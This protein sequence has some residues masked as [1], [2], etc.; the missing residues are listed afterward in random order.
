MGTR[1]ALTAAVVAVWCMAGLTP[2]ATLHGE[3]GVA[4]LE[5]IE[6][7]FIKL[8]RQVSPSVVALETEQDGDPSQGQ[9]GVPMVGSGVVLDRDGLILTNDHVVRFADRVVVTLNT[10]RRYEAVVVAR[11]ERSDLA[12]LRIAAANLAPV[13][14]GDLAQTSVGQFA[15]AMGNPFG[16]GKDG[17]LSLSY[18]IVSAL[19][20]S[21]HGLEDGG[22]KYYGN[23][24]QTTADIK[25]GNSGGPLFDI[26]GRLIGINTAIETRGGSAEGLGYA[27]PLSART[28]RIITTLS[29]GQTVQYG[30]LGVKIRDPDDRT[31]RRYGVQDPFG[32][33][34]TRVDAQTPAEQAGIRP[35]DLILKFASESIRDVDHLIRLVGSSPVGEQV[36]LVVQRRDR[37][38]VVNAT[39]GQRDDRRLA[40]AGD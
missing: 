8:A 4:D 26:H 15:L 29:L 33:V 27:I 38:L 30:F 10:G 28:K 11:D 5:A 34:V 22:R 7:A 23:L 6:N 1:S 37:Q 36:P 18:G 21:L 16:T 13:V 9:D 19:G 20:K 40:G 3:T 17:N 31:R 2:L 24:I 35:D 25:P 32:V 39:I 12:V 14:M